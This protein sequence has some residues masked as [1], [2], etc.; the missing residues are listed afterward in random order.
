MT[1]PLTVSAAITSW[2]GGPAP[3]DTRR[4][5]VMMHGYG[6]N[7]ADLASLAPALPR[8]LAWASLRAPLT[9]APGSYSWFPLTVPGNPQPEPVL[10][11]T[12]A[13]SA[14]IDENIPVG[15]GVVSLGFSQGGLMASQLLRAVP[16][17][18]EATV[19]LGGFV[20]A[21][22]LPGDDALADDRPP[23]FD[24][25]G[26]SDTVIAA[27]AVARAHDWLPGHSTLT[28]RIYPG[29]GHGIDA[30]ELADVVAFLEAL[31]NP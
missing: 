11:A 15:V 23:V 7:E 9:L 4:V 12:E 10:A 31:P 3:A 28:E 13:I 8:G 20:L 5:V 25:R 1:E 22:P 6:S 24:G 2:G 21:S 18:V 17:R 14:W 30:T 29:L 16:R 19:I 27:D 26:A